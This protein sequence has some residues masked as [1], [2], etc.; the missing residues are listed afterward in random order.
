MV[1]KLPLYK[2]WYIIVLDS[3]S[4]YTVPIHSGTS[5]GLVLLDGGLIFLGVIPDPGA[6]R[7]FQNGSSWFAGDLFVN[8]I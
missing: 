2:M 6:G 7:D 8:P 5:F 3:V 1:E 4:S